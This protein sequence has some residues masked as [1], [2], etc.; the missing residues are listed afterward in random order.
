MVLNV[1]DRGWWYTVRSSRC[2]ASRSVSSKAWE[3]PLE[4]YLKTWLS[5]CFFLYYVYKEVKQP[6][7]LRS[8]DHCQL[9]WFGWWSHLASSYF[10]YKQCM[11]QEWNTEV[12][13]RER[14]W[15]SLLVSL[16]PGW[17][18]NPDITVADNWSQTSTY[19]NSFSL[20]CVHLSYLASFY[21]AF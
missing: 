7:G 3:Y 20:R 18:T 19:F 8:F 14:W 1:A 4:P 6:T 11:T 2:V 12:V 10:I 13:M 9:L 21:I 15:Q 17:G 5:G 16:V